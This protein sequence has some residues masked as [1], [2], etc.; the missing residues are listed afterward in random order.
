MIADINQLIVAGALPGIERI[1]PAV[2]N[3]MGDVPRH[4]FVP[5]EVAARAY[6]DQPLAIG[7]ES[8]ISAPLIVAAM[9]SLLQ[10]AS[11]HKVLEVGTGSGYQAAVL[12]KLV[13]QV[14]SVEIVAPLAKAAAERLPRLGYRNVSVRPGDGYAGWPEHAPFDR[15]IVT[16]GAT[17][18]PQPL[19]QQLKAGGRMVIPMGRTEDEQRLVLVTKDKAGKVR[20]RRLARV[21]FVPLNESARPRG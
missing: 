7:Y 12:A 16:A 11:D 21:I 9:T 20:T 10:P 18:V 3:V 13:R 1:D 4:L 8:T 14:Y 17:H 15:I 2:L 19:V 5:D 6:A